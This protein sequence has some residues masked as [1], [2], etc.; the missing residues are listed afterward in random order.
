ME[1]FSDVNP[2]RK[3]TLDETLPTTGPQ[4]CVD[5]EGL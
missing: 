1:T 5:G 4:R 2:L 3:Q